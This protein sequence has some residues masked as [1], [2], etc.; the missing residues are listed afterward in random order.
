[1]IGS[2]LPCNELR[3]IANLTSR[4]S[5]LDNAKVDLDIERVQR[6]NGT[7]QDSLN[8]TDRENHYEP[9]SGILVCMASLS[10]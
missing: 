8:S 1:M 2:E 6:D 3:L 10:N 9:V 7:M 5:W 4:P